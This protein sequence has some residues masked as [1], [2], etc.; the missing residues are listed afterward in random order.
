MKLAEFFRALLFI[1][2]VEKK[3]FSRRCCQKIYSYYNF[4][5]PIF[6]FYTT[7]TMEHLDR[8]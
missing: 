5:F 3:M 7:W 1:G 4:L 6:H 2:D 8:K